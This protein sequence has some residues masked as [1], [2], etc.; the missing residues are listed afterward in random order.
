MNSFKKAIGDFR[1][2]NA[3]A[4]HTIIVWGNTLKGGLNEREF[5]DIRYLFLEDTFLIGKLD[6]I[7]FSENFI[8][9]RIHSINK[10]F[11]RKRITKSNYRKRNY[12]QFDTNCENEILIIHHDCVIANIWRLVVQSFLE[13]NNITNHISVIKFDGIEWMI[14]DKCTDINIKKSYESYKSVLI[15]HK[16]IELTKYNIPNNF[17]NAY[18][19]L[20]EFSGEFADYVLNQCKRNS[21]L[22]NYNNF[23]RNISFRY[24]GL[25]IEEFKYYLNSSNNKNY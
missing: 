3:T 5:P 16:F 10:Y 19:D 13:I 17:T 23:L 9:K 21:I 22:P 7:P 18:L 24:Y 20:V 12:L 4:R 6:E 8:K 25:S 2:K 11:S 14:P 15:N 1:S